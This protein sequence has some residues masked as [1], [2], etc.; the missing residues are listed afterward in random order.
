VVRLDRSEKSC[1]IPPLTREINLKPVRQALPQIRTSKR[2]S[3]ITP[4]VL[5]R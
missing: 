4:A 5:Q 1:D 2:A 3:E